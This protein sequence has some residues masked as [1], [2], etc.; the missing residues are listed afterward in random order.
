[1]L[2]IRENTLGLTILTGFFVANI[3]SEYETLVLQKT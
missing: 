2:L 1:M 3:F